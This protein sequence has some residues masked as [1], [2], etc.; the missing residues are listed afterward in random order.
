MF[1]LH[2]HTAPWYFADGWMVCVRA[3]AKNRMGGYTG[4]QEFGYL[5]RNG[6]IVQE[7]PQAKC[8]EQQFTEWTEMEGAGWKSSTPPSS[9]VDNSAPR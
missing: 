7:G 4:R 9:D 3:N 2:L 6:V 5:I 8:P 1:G